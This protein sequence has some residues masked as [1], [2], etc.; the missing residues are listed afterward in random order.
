MRVT[1]KATVALIVAAEFA[2]A[3]YLALLAWLL[4]AWMVDD[5]RAFR[6]AASDWYV[7][8]AW[9]FGTVVVVGALFGVLTHVINRRWLYPRLGSA[10]RL[11]PLWAVLLA[12]FVVL[13]GAAG[14]ALFVATKPFM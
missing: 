10:S 4:S 5:S 11:G 9:R 6:M 12:A 14:T 7:E 8:G 13:S 3:A 1:G 2:S